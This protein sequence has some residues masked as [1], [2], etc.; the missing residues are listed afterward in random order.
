MISFDQG[1]SFVG[2]MIIFGKYDAGIPYVNTARRAMV[3]LATPI[4]VESKMILQDQT[5]IESD[6]DE[7]LTFK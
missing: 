3:A 1:Q 7:D 5:C 6:A 2:G 4:I